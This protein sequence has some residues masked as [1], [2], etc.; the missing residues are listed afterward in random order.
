MIQLGDIILYQLSD[1]DAESI[2]RR[3][4]HAAH[5][6][7]MMRVRKDGYQ[8]HFGNRVGMGEVVAMI[9]TKVWS[10]TCVN[11]QAVLDGNDSLWLTS[12]CE[13]EGPGYWSKRTDT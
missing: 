12:A 4:R 2:N 5:N 7:G 8:S 13:G 6:R 3:Y 11:G 1:I 9:V 10:S